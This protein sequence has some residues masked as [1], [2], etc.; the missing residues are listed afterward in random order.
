VRRERKGEGSKREEREG[1]GRGMEGRGGENDL[2]HPL[3]R[4]PG[5]ATGLYSYLV[6]F[7]GYRLHTFHGPSF[8]PSIPSSRS[9]LPPYPFLPFPFHSLPFPVPFP[10]LIVDLEFTA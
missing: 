2:T 6:S 10:F 3:S 1:E 5:Y 9:S 7:M 4:I 8:R